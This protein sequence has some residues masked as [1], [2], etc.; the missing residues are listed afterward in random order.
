M[1]SRP[2]YLALV[3]G[4]G[5]PKPG[6]AL[7]DFP[8]V[9]LLAAAGDTGPALGSAQFF[10]DLTRAGATAEIHVYQKGHHGFGDGYASGT[11]SDWMG[12]LEHFLKQGG[13]IPGGKQ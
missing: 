9:F 13:F 4:P 5:R 11:F 3:Y 12:R 10:M 6:E 7:K 2:D 8:P 1:S